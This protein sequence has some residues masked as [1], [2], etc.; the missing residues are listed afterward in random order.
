LPQ[1]Y[2]ECGDHKASQHVLETNPHFSA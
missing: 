2:R 1:H